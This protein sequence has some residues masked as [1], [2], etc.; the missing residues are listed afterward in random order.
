MID[1]KGRLFGKLNIVDLLIVIILAAALAFLGFKLLGPESDAAN[2]Q[3]VTLTL[4][5]EDTPDFVAE[6][7][8]AGSS[9]WDSTAGVTLGTLAEWRVG[10]SKSYVT[11]ANDNVVE[12]TR[13]E[14]C[15]LTLTVQASGV[16]S[17]HGVTIGGTLYGVGHSMTVYAGDC[18]IYLKVSDIG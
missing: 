2:T 7:L 1:E 8:L 11:D 16:V 4:Y 13:E 14:Y 9:V 5:C 3:D 12:L 15:S 17:E 6:Q 10:D 18:K